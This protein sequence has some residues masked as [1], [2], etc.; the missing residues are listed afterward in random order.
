[1]KTPDTKTIL[2]LTLIAAIILV[3]KKIGDKLHLWDTAAD[4]TSKALDEGSTSDITNVSSAAPVGLAL[5]PKYWQYIYASAKKELAKKKINI[6]GKEVLHSLTIFGTNP[7][8]PSEI[9]VLT[10][11]DIVK[12]FVPI[13][14]IYN[15]KNKIDEFLKTKKLDTL[16]QTYAVL[17]MQIENSKGIFSDDPER[18]NSVFQRLNSKAQISY[19][20]GVFLLLYG[21][22]LLSYLQ[23]FLNTDEQAKIYNIIK[24]KPLYAN[25]K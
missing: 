2:N 6:T 5:N 7:L 22:D 1:M 9:T 4:T 20:S 14:N 15:A 23:T 12:S 24:N 3:G 8:K 16:Q 10:P 11:F 25:L 18:I 21:K 13:Y 17:C 19:L